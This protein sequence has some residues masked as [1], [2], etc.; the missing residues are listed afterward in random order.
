M[1]DTKDAKKCKGFT[2]NNE[3]QLGDLGLRNAV[4]GSGRLRIGWIRFAQTMRNNWGK[5]L[6]VSEQ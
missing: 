2:E 4:N 5:S 6:V 1:K 3:E